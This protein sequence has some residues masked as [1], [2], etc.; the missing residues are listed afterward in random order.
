MALEDKIK[1]LIRDDI[2]A[3]SAYH[4]PDPGELVKLDAMENPY[5]LPDAIRREW[6]DVLSNAKLNRYPDPDARQL[7]EVLRELM[8][9]PDAVDIILGN[10]SDE[11]IQMIAMSVAKVD[12]VIMAPEPSFV[13]YQM[14]ATFCDMR[15][16][17]VPLRDDFSLDM[18][19]ML[20][21]IKAKQPAVIFLAYPNNPTGNLF[22][23]ADVRKIIEVTS[24]LVV[25]DEAY[26]SFASRSM[27]GAINEYENL[28]VMRT[29]SKMGLAGLRLGMLM[30]APEWLCEINKV[31]LPY[32]INILTQ[33]SAGFLLR[34]ADVFEAQAANIRHERHLM[35]E[36]LNRLHNVHAY[37]SEANFI[38]FRLTAADASDVFAELKTQGVLIKNMTHASPALAGCMRVTV[39]AAEE[40]QQFLVALEKCLS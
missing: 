2:R 15:Y 31:R 34:H 38:L 33:L 24:G 3:L 19:A 21:A 23:E 26:T 6:L 29:V 22:S 36:R 40:N 37:P 18:D 5:P 11:L 13:M 7:K 25:V 20:Q 4:V 39:G 32:N 27:L 9:L 17:G 35:I 8:Q 30:G 28:L 10:G 14:I 12:A 1:T 16:A